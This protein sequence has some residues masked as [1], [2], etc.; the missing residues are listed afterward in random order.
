MNPK[1]LSQEQNDSETSLG[2]EGMNV[3]CPSQAHVL[4]FSPY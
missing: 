4:N 3:H 1:V 2:N